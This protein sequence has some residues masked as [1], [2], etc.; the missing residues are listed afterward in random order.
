MKKKKKEPK[1]KMPKKPMK[2]K[3]SC[4]GQGCDIQKRILPF[5]IIGDIKGLKKAA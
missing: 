2:P 4:G 1:P 5:G 3:M